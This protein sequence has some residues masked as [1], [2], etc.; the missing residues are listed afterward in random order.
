MATRS[1]KQADF[2]H[3][4]RNIDERNP[5]VAQLSHDAKQPSRFVLGQRRG[6]L[7]KHKQTHARPQ[8]RA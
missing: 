5:V 7:V 6:R 4:M 8:T 3:S 2:G 1:A